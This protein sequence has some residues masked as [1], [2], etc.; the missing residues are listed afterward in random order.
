MLESIVLSYPALTTMAGVADREEMIRHMEELEEEL[1]AVLSQ[2]ILSEVVSTLGFFDDASKQLSASKQPTR[3]LVPLMVEQ[4]RRHLQPD[5][6]DRPL[7]EKFSY[8]RMRSRLW[9]GPL[10]SLG[11]VLGGSATLIFEY[12][13]RVGRVDP[14]VDAATAVAAPAATA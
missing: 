1:Q 14:P 2:G 11:R 13:R 5:A 3:F 9:G 8:A 10:P 7:V 6:A 4:S 12:L